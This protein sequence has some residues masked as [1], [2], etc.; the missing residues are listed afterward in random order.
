MAKSGD[1]RDQL[2]D[3][4][5]NVRKHSHMM[6][7]GRVVYNDDNNINAPLSMSLS[8]HNTVRHKQQPDLF[9]ENQLLA[10]LIQQQAMKKASH[11]AA[12]PINKLM[13]QMKVRTQ[14]PTKPNLTIL[15]NDD[16][17]E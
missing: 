4:I 9:N 11:K 16:F 17:Q 12:L 10:E 8:S 2:M 1:S 7:D 13:K 15:R 14:Q 3:K 6:P 5:L